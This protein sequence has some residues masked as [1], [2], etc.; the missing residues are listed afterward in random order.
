MEENNTTP[1]INNQG[2][3]F[4]QEIPPVV[5]DN[6][7]PN[8]EIELD[9]VFNYE[10]PFNPGELG[11]QPFNPQPSEPIAPVMPV[12]TNNEYVKLEGS[13][14]SKGIKVFAVIIAILVVF[15]GAVTGGYLLGKHR[16]GIGESVP[17][18]LASKPDPEDAMTTSQVYNKVNTSVVGVY[19]YNKDGSTSNATGVIYSKDGYVVTN[20]HIYSGITAP[21]FK[22]YTSDGAVYDAD[23][24]AGDLRSDLAVLKIKD[25]LNLEPATFGNSNE[26]TVGETVVAIGRPNGASK[27]STISEG[28]ISV[29]ST[30]VSTT[31][32]YTSRLIQTDTALNPGN[33]GG[34][35][36]NVYG[37]VIGITSAKLVGDYEGVSYAIPTTTVKKIVDSLIKNKTVKNR[38]RLG[39]SYYKIDAV[40][41]EILNLPCGLKIGEIDKDSDLYGKSVKTDDVI[42]H[43]NGQPITDDEFVLNVIEDSSAGDKITLT[44]YSASTKKSFDVTVKL[45]ADEG[46]SSYVGDANS[47]NSKYNSSQFD[48]PNGE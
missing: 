3:E 40:Q 29:A 44:I 16:G 9:P 23:Y 33:S 35:L 24:V 36:C 19:V 6:L 25:G 13:G 42:T 1:N 46:S 48:F 20:D 45:L 14:A 2:A 15:S 39:I 31:T 47:S 21:K 17:V 30:R 41:S 10:Q 38:A 32:T 8:G 34:A 28:I 27:A 43:I 7:Q 5:E 26:I 37:Q 18:D 11:A 22:V 4:P 12:I